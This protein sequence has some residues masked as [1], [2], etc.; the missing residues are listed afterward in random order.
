MFAGLARRHDGAF[1]VGI[2]SIAPLNWKSESVYAASAAPPRDVIPRHTGSY[3]PLG[4]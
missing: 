2:G 3:G 4:T 1:D